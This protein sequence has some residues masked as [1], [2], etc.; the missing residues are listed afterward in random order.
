ME[1]K[2][3]PEKTELT[4]CVGEA[5]ELSE[6]SGAYVYIQWIEAA[7]NT[8]VSSPAERTQECVPLQVHG[9][10]YAVSEGCHSNAVHTKSCSVKHTPVSLE[11]I[12]E[13]SVALGH[14]ASLPHPQAISMQIALRTHTHV[15]CVCTTR[16]SR[17]DVSK[18]RRLN[19]S[20]LPPFSHAQLHPFTNA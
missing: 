6:V 19:Q 20:V 15:C 16:C 14:E 9:R 18:P 17:K 12:Q 8:T 2:L 11:A 10:S 3:S 4:F 13:E 5:G 1:S 7:L